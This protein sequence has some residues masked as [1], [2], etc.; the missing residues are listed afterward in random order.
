MLIQDTFKHMPVG[1][2]S[3]RM[4]NIPF[5]MEEPQMEQILRI[6]GR[7]LARERERRKQEI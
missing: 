5:G 4:N 2:S 3:I 6:L 7:G 1:F